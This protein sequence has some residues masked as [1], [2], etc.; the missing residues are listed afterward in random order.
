MMLAFFIMLRIAITP[1]RPRKQTTEFH[2]SVIDH[3]LNNN[4][5]LA[6]C[7][8]EKLETFEFAP[9]LASPTDHERPRDGAI[10]AN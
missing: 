8:A 6:S 1:V 2:A 7:G 4:N 3:A 10:I 9:Q 5:C